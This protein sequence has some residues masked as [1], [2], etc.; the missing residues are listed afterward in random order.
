MASFTCTRQDGRLCGRIHREGDEC[1]YAP[2]EGGHF[3]QIPER[4]ATGVMRAPD[5][6]KIAVP[7]RGPALEAGD[8]KYLIDCGGCAAYLSLIHI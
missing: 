5:G 4:D 1:C 3:V 2:E 8:G 6:R 7:Y